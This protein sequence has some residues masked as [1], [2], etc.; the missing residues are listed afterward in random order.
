MAA[1]D[2]IVDILIAE[3][4]PRLAASPVWPLARPFLYALLGYRNA[5][6]MADK[7]AALTGAGAMDYVSDLL[8]LKVAVSGLDRIPP[9]GRCVIVINHPTGIADGVAIYDAIKPRRR[10]SI[11]F[12]NA[13]ALRVSARLGEVVI[14]VEW[15]AEKRTREKTRDTLQRAREAFEAER[16]V[17]VF[18]AGRLARVVRG[19]LTDEPWASSA[20]AL[21][22]RFSAPIIPVHLSGPDSFFFH[23]FDLFS[24]ELR[25]ITLFHEMLNKHHK[26]FGVT[27]G[28][29]I[30][31]DRLAGDPEE[32]TL[33]IKAYVER[34]LPLHPDQPF[35]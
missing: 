32:V 13:D 30:S 27:V 21:A 29:P 10:D 14:P 17:V 4:A 25:D 16:C 22:R 19:A 8:Q 5:R 35:A 11:F 34:V 7:V 23:A 33:A 18:P 28:L 12:A 31:P 26:R 6:A 20:V 3:R 1:P 9:T 24:Q 15:V 2:H